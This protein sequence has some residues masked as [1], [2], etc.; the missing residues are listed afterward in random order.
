MSCFDGR[1]GA[2]FELANGK[3]LGLIDLQDEGTIAGRV[4]ISPDKRVIAAASIRR[5]ELNLE[6]SL[7]LW[8][9]HS[10][11]LLKRYLPAG[12]SIGALEFT[13]DGR[14]LISGMSD[15]T[16]LIWDVPGTTSAHK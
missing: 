12:G 7:R 10:G 4:A 1:V 6:Y 5:G 14:R 11:R 15:G 13:P 16:A 9:A 3:Q 2:I 8:D